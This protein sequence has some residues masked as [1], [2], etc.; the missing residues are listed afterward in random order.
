MFQL[1]DVEELDFLPPTLPKK[2]SGQQLKQAWNSRT[3]GSYLLAKFKRGL[4]PNQYERL[5]VV[6]RQAVSV[7]MRLPRYFKMTFSEKNIQDAQQ[8]LSPK[9]SRARLEYLT[10]LVGYEKHDL[11]ADPNKPQQVPCIRFFFMEEKDGR[12]FFYKFKTKNGLRNRRH[13]HLFDRVMDAWRIPR[14]K[15]VFLDKRAFSTHNL[16]TM[17]AQFFQD[18]NEKLALTKPHL[19]SF[20]QY[21]DVCLENIDFCQ[22]CFS[23]A[24]KQVLLPRHQSLLDLISRVEQKDEMVPLTVLSFDIEQFSPKLSSGVRPFPQIGNPKCVV[25]HVGVSVRENARTLA[26]LCFCV[27]KHKVPENSSVEN[28]ILK[29]YRTEEQMLQAFCNYLSATDFDVLSGFNIVGYDI[30]VIYQRLY[31]MY[32]SSKYSYEYLVT[33]HRTTKDKFVEYKKLMKNDIQGYG[34]AQQIA[35]IFDIRSQDYSEMI[36]VPQ[37]YYCLHKVSKFTRQIYLEWREKGKRIDIEKC[38]HFGSIAARPIKY[39]ESTLSTQA[40]GDLAMHSFKLS[41]TGFIVMDAWLVCKKMAKKLDSYSL[42]FVMNHFLPEDH[43]QKIDMPY[44]KMFQ[45]IEKQDPVG[46]GAVAEYCCRDAEAPI[47]LLEKLTSLLELRMFSSLCRLRPAVTNSCGQQR[48]IISKLQEVCHLLEFFINEYQKIEYGQSYQ[49]ATVIDPKTGFHQEPVATLDFA[50]L[51]PSIMI[52]YNICFSTID[53]DNLMHKAT[54]QRFHQIK[55]GIGT[56]HY[57]QNFVGVL[58]RLEQELLSARKA[59]KKQMKS[60]PNSD[61]YKI[62]NTRQLSIKVLCNSVYGF[63]GVSAG[64]MPLK[65]LAASV[66]SEGRRLIEVETKNKCEALGYE[67]VY[68]S[69]VTGV[70]GCDCKVVCGDLLIVFF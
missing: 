31:L 35:G 24:D 38:F 64:R 25:T 36:Q 42:K 37:L 21:F 12:S 40:F 2:A 56:A 8:L 55:T 47:I 60:A 7:V 30:K 29:C 50:S 70:C 14:D 54:T 68:G 67:V 9:A 49:G 33:K 23:K 4:A 44:E 66:T 11:L 45:L 6:S 28:L 58:P 22:D 15:R 18:L 19:A 46:L 17:T 53:L 41:T 13:D 63:V 27:G 34:R 5:D 43:R 51:Y 61:I 16:T 20:D 3:Q 1:L 52:A 10:P 62:L 65:I 48:K 32:L 59:V 69:S 57:A 26:N 39:E